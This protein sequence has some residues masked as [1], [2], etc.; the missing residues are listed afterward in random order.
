[1]KTDPSSSVWETDRARI[2]L[3]GHLNKE[4]EYIAVYCLRDRYIPVIILILVPHIIQVL[5]LLIDLCI[6]PRSHLLG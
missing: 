3:V 2:N 6:L 4:T 1:M 5:I